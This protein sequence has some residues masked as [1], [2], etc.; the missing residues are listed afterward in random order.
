MKKIL[1]TTLA[2]ALV[3]ASAFALVGCDDEEKA[4]SPVT[5]TQYVQ[6]LAK[7]AQSFYGAHKIDDKDYSFDIL[8][9][10]EKSTAQLNYENTAYGELTITANSEVKFT[11]VNEKTYL[12][13]ETIKTVEEKM[14]V[15]MKTTNTVSVKKVGAYYYIRSNQATSGTNSLDNFDEE[16]KTVYTTTTTTTGTVQYDLG[17]YVNGETVTY[18]YAKNETATITETST[19][20]DFTP[21]EDNGVAQNTKAYTT[22]TVEEYYEAVLDVL[23]NAN[24]AVR[25]MALDTVS[26][27]DVGEEG[28]VMEEKYSKDG[29]NLVLSVSMF[30]IQDID[31]YDGTVATLNGTGKFVINETSFVS[32]EMN[33]A[34]TA[35]VGG[36]NVKSSVHF[37]NTAA[38][39]PF[40]NLDG[41][42]LDESLNFNGSNFDISMGFDL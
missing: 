3:G 27:L 39:T 6:T 37:A 11:D 8:N 22:L 16:T 19:E 2:I 20:P 5:K 7:A 34:M 23:E 15:E 17:V 30:G 33:M 32:V 12:D 38:F 24:D 26:E 21:N 25:V 35:P 29:N 18:Y 14:N 9:G 10:V 36:M 40:A 4:I 13:G 1:S 31:V 41:Y 28:A 42:D